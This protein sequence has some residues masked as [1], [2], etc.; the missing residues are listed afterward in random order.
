MAFKLD[1]RI[2]LTLII[3]LTIFSAQLD[4]AFPPSLEARLENNEITNI[5]LIGIDARPE[6]I[7]A[8]SDTIMLLS[9]N[10]QIKQA[11]IISIPRDTRIVFQGKNRKINMVNQLKGPN[12]L[13][14]EVST[15]M[16]TSV[17][18]YILTNFN[19]FK[20][21]IDQ[22]GGIWIDVDIDLHSPATGVYLGKGYQCLSGQEALT[23]VRFRSDVD[24]DI[25][26][27]QRQQ[28]FIAAL[29]EQMLIKE[30]LP[31]LPGI[32]MEI[33][34]NVQTNISLRDMVYLARL[35]SEYKTDDLITQTLP[36][37]HYWAQNSGASFWE[38]DREIA[39]SVID[40]LFNGHRYET[41]LE[42]PPWVNSY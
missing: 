9:I 24:G 2:L 31:R 17:E 16:G 22:L 11:A 29:A 21:I 32:V 39:R 41:R 28:R 14:Q 30:N 13:C 7:N 19:N 15:L 12:A 25:G 8:R 38:V 35:A 40:S 4:S 36:G 5:L 37:Y 42:A 10:N 20:N 26:R 23:Y 18:H 1:P 6:E 34:E 27:A 3:S 33:K